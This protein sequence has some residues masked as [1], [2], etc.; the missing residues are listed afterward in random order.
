M[1]II[2]NY[3]KSTRLFTLDSIIINHPEKKD[4]KGT[5]SGINDNEVLSYIVT[6]SVYYLK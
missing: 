6:F 1:G 2:E 4:D 3:E 5:S